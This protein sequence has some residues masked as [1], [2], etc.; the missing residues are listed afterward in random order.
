MAGL[1]LLKRYIRWLIGVFVLL[2]MA[3]A[4]G[5]AWLERQWQQPLNLPHGG[6]TLTVNPGQSLGGVL[7]IAERDGWLKHA[8][9]LGF[10]AAQ[11][12]LDGGI[13]VGEYRIAQQT[14]V[15]SLVEQLARGDVYQRQITLPEGITLAQA[16][17]VLC[18]EESLTCTLT[19]A[20]DPRLLALV[21][22]YTSAEGWFLPETYRYTRGDSDFDV[23]QRAHRLMRNT[24]EDHWQRR[25]TGLPLD[26]PYQALVL[27]SIV[28]RE[29]G[30]ANERPTIAGVFVRRLQ[31]G[32][33]LQT[34]PTII[35]GLGEKFDGNLTRSHLRDGSNPYNTYRIDGLP[36]TPIALPGR[37]AI[38]AAL[39]P[40]EG[41]A[42]YFVARGDGSHAFAATLAE[43]E[44]NVRQ[45]QLNRRE[46]YRSAPQ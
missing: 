45:F 40:E 20:A 19:G 27:A 9:V 30:M 46:N 38:A 24:L 33:R 39:S 28:E 43:H 6:A 17:A 13:H 18:G 21:A 42:L 2:V 35:Y 44:E 41:D 29:T 10:L 22:P 12:S 25:A 31:R 26:T 4:A 11:K 37:E 16:I 7:R 23:L 1:R 3:G 14:T 34:D 5:I 8:R 15:A 32:M 36:P